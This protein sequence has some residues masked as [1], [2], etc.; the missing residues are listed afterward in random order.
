VGK[1]NLEIA[2]RAQ[3]ALGLIDTVENVVWVDTETTALSTKGAVLELYLEER[4]GDDAHVVCRIADRYR[5]RP[6]AR[7][8]KEAMNVNGISL[9][10]LKDCDEFEAGGVARIKAWWCSPD[11]PRCK[12]VIVGW[13]VTFDVKH[14][15]AA[16]ERDDKAAQELEGFLRAYA[17][18][19]KVHVRKLLKSVGG[20]LPVGYRLSN[21][22]DYMAIDTSKMSGAHTA[23]GDV[24]RMQA[25]LSE[26]ATDSPFVLRALKL[27]WKF[28]RWL[29]GKK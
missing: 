26:V 29:R 14:L 5:P 19:A 11:V 6:D 24:E 27:K 21:M 17:I 16:I 4:T 18:D 25:V 22:V 7:I 8:E 23:R 9:P 10:T 12:V 13:N 3:A 20:G 2:R 15:H 28:K 1:S